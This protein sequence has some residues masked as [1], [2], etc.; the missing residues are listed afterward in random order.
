MS[1]QGS[2]LYMSNP[3]ESNESMNELLLYSEQILCIMNTLLY[4]E[5]L[6]DGDYVTEYHG[7]E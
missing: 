2:K 7:I 5:C 4:N 6:C 1:A 3:F